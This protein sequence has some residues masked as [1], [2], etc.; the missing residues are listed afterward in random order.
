MS[1]KDYLTPQTAFNSKVGRS[2]NAKASSLSKGDMVIINQLAAEFTDRSKKSIQSW[3]DYLDA[4]DHPET[5][6]WSGLQDLYEYLRPDGHLGSQRDIRKGITEATRYFIRDSKTMKEMPDKTKLLEQEWFFNMIGDLLDH[7]FDGYTVLQFTDALNGKYDLIPRRNF[8]PQLDMILTESRGTKGVII[9]D[10]AFAGSIVVIKNQYKFGILNDVVP[11]LIWKKTSRQC[12]AE[13]SQKFGIP[14]TTATTNSRDKKELD[15]IEAMLKALGR[16]AQAVFPQGTTLDIKDTAA[17]GD[18]FNVFLKQMEYCDA[19]ISKRF[20]GGTMVSDNGSSK[21]Q[22]EVHQDTLNYI[23]AERDKKKIEFCI[24]NQVLPILRT[25][26]YPITDTDEFV[27]DRSEDLTLKEHW[28][29][30]AKAVELGYDIKEEWISEN[31]NFPING[32]R[33]VP[34]QP[35]V[36]SNAQARATSF[37][38]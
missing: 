4:A 18:P 33:I 38:S 17:K 23:I 8:V 29:I 3:R 6:N 37:F 5:P 1:Y 35:V 15:R 28:D 7:I 19:Q 24:N 13:F 2:Y 11:D 36:A 26:G 10:P 30:I 22:A 14:L 16:A 12:W 27:F 31:F 20:L 9:T 34:T 21:S 32:K 25:A